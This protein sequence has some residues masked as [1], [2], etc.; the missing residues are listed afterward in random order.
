[1][2]RAFSAR[3]GTFSLFM[4]TVYKTSPMNK[5]TGRFLFLSVAFSTLFF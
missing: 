3:A 1:M 2:N 4:G 5:A